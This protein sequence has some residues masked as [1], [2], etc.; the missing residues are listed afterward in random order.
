[1]EMANDR[2]VISCTEPSL[3]RTATEEHIKHN[4]R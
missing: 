3:S 1:M 4:I 2:F